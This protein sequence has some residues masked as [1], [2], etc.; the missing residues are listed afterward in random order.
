[1]PIK[2]KKVTTSA[3][4]LMSLLRDVKEIS[5]EDAA[6][7]LGVPMATLENW[8]TFLEEERALTIKYKF[9][10]PYL[11]YTDP[12]A[13]K[14][15]PATVQFREKLMPEAE[16]EEGV[17]RVGELI[18]KA[19]AQTRKGE[20]GSVKQTLTML[21]AEARSLKESLHLEPGKKLNVDKKLSELELSM[22]RANYYADTGKFDAANKLYYS[23]LAEIKD[24]LLSLK[25]AKGAI[26]KEREQERITDIKQLLDK[27]YSLM[28]SGKLDEAMELYE[29]LNRRYRTL[30]N[31]FLQ[32]KEEIEKNLIKLNK[33]ISLSLDRQSIALMKEGSKKIIE[34]IKQ[35]KDATG[36]GDF[37]KA[38][39]AYY[40]IRK[41][42]EKLP[43]GFAKEQRDLKRQ[44]LELFEAI[45]AKRKETLTQAFL[46]SQK[47]LT[48]SLAIIE[49]GISSGNFSQSSAEYNSVKKIY[50]SVPEEFLKEKLQMYEQLRVAYQKLMQLYSEQSSKKMGEKSEE[51][52]RLLIMMKEQV[53]SNSIKSAEETYGKIKEAFISLP[54]GFVSEKTELQRM[55]IQGYEYFLSRS[56]SYFNADIAAKKA[57]IER[58]MGDALSYLKSGRIELAEEVYNE[59]IKEYNQFAPGFS[60]EM[61]ALRPRLLDVYR[62]III[63]KQSQLIRDTSTDVSSKYNEIRKLLVESHMNV[64]RRMFELLEPDYHRIRKL[65]NELPLG[66]IRENYQLSKSI[67]NLAKIVDFNKKI[68]AAE[69]AM[70]EKSPELKT[71]LDEAMALRK[72]LPEAEAKNLVD[73][74]E[75]KKPYFMK[76]IEY[77]QG[78]TGTPA[79]QPTLASQGTTQPIPIPIP[80]PRIPLPP[81][82][83]K[84]PAQAG[85]QTAVQKP[86]KMQA[87]I[88]LSIPAP[89][90]A[91][92]AGSPK[93]QQ[94]NPR[95]TIPLPNKAL[96]ANEAENLGDLRE[97]IAR[98]R[99]SAAPRVV[100][101]VQVR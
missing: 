54:P 79:Q 27:A 42:F 35:C 71:I 4:L 55:I 2:P 26:E 3:D 93:M 97:K 8:A 48:D 84:S 7:N 60:Y 25:K 18:E 13:S 76:A 73:Y 37:T 6:K 43:S 31:E 57:A 78:R 44:I 20:F 92:Q 87:K 23:A 32:R 80:K 62:E 75:L 50:D 82:Q 40:E 88:N 41:A 91:M 52:R 10:T 34:L 21:L 81:A 49:R 38:E 70:H 65:F 36:K 1:M 47:Q 89:P 77:A 22:Q 74:F 99:I 15:H 45:A 83:A 46:K 69:K 11:V 39:E 5:L 95:I 101:P 30:P 58:L 63:R 53:D 59:I 16:M 19:E 100:M 17:E 98:L 28:E 86:I 67:S 66:F 96:P 56:E 85:Q 90:L 61:S 51:I 12:S 9:T 68:I 72:G 64:N 94:S 14:Q 33:D 29:Q 24:L